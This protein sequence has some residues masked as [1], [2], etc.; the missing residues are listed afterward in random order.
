MSS[1]PDDDLW[2]R[3]D[4]LFDQ[5]LD[6]PA[7]E[8]GAFLDRAC[9]GEAELRA[10][11]ERLLGSA[12]KTAPANRAADRALSG[13]L[14]GGLGRELEAAGENEPPAGTQ[15]GRYRLVREIGRGGMAVVYLAERADGQFEQ[16]VA[17]KLLKRGFDTDELVW[18][19]DQERQILAA[20][21]HPGLARLLDAGIGPDSRPYLV[22]EYVEGRPIDRYCDE[23]RLPV[24]E[25]LQL[26]LQVA[27]AVEAAHRSLVVHRDIKPNNI[28]VTAD[29]HAKLLDFGIAKILDPA[30]DTTVPL[31]RTRTT[32]RLLTPAW[33]S[34]EQVLGGPITTASDVYQLGLLLYVLLSGRFPYLLAQG[35]AALA[36][37]AIAAAQPARA[38]A[39]A[40]GL[41]GGPPPGPPGAAPP[42]PEAA[43]L[44]R[45]TTPAR[46]RRELA[47][48]LDTILLTALR[49]EPERRY[50]SV[51]L[52]AEDLQRFLAGRPVAARRD[53]TLYR[54]AK[55]LR[56]NAAAVTA[57]VTG[58]ALVVMVAL[59]YTHELARER[60]RARQAAERA[61]RVAAFLGDLFEVAAPAGS[62]GRQ[63]TAREM[64]DRGAGRLGS[65][66][67]AEPELRADLLLVVGDVYRQLAQ[68]GEARPLFERAVAIR[69]AAPGEDRLGLAAALHG[70]GRLE[71]DAGRL[72]PARRHLEEALAIRRAAYVY[73]YG[74]HPDIGRTLDALGAVLA[75]AGDFQAARRH[76]QEALALLEAGLPADDPEVGLAV[77]NL[78][79]TYKQER[80]YRPA[81]ACF[82]RALAQLEAAEGPDHP[83]VAATL[84]EIADVLDAAEESEEARAAYLQAL[85][86]V[87]RSYGPAHPVFASTL[88]ALAN[89]L[90][91]TGEP[92]QAV[93]LLRRAL[94]VRE[95][96]LGPRHPLVAAGWND[97]G[98]A[99]LA[100]DDAGAARQAFEQSAAAYRDSLAPDDS[101]SA[102]PL[103]NLAG[104]EREAGR[105]A[106]ALA[107]YRRSLAIRQRAFGAGH[108][109]LVMP[110]YYVG[111]LERELGAPAAAEQALR[112]AIR[113]AERQPGGEHARPLFEVE[114]ARSLAAQRR[115]AEASALLSPHAAE[116]AGQTLRR[117][118]LAALAELA[119][120]EGRLAEAARH[121]AALAR[122]GPAKA[123]SRPRPV[124][125]R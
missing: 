117:R 93:A 90:R 78:G 92:E 34:P 1:L 59:G 39:A 55:F 3:A 73:V 77:R 16:Q 45:G 33:A 58:I 108:D 63:V 119:T 100:A 102:N 12:E 118:A 7:A 99:H 70:L 110:W 29:G 91:A 115:F 94:A 123:A 40:A 5:A 36:A 52:F 11:V 21:S 114:L 24:A 103:F 48:D 10:L 8:R 125:A 15:V 81:L 98:L 57:A 14:R 76:H 113:L 106:E 64:L 69:R 96:A 38:S 71:G 25:R 87:E 60:D 47:G 89:L 95:A 26:V 124:I 107:L 85:P 28:L 49:K 32:A 62:L 120:A 109:S 104:M 105:R 50:R 46:L 67:A 27:R 112:Q 97:L 86:V 80:L 54:A 18:R 31:A 68:F 121:R 72:G 56:R 116:S 37:Q 61:T 35:A 79:L 9:G 53:S 23:E 65:E 6:L 111:V 51:S 83:H 2:D 13:L 88:A 4:R 74:G 75:A 43:A 44:A 41:A 30:D 22:L 101:G 122:L 20:A 66:L 17:L 82:R 84:V 19:F 42:D